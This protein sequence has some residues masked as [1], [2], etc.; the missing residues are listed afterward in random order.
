[1]HKKCSLKEEGFLS[2]HCS[3]EVPATAV[4]VGQSVAAEAA[5]CGGPS[6]DDDQEAES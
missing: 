4:G 1:M 6:H 5:C 3:E 2:V